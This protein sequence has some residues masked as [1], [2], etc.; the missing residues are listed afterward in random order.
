MTGHN[1]NIYNNSSNT[2]SNTSRNTFHNTFR[3]KIHNRKKGF[4]LIETLLSLTIFLV[5]MAGVYML[6]IHYAKATRTEQSRQRLNQEI[7]FMTNVFAGEIKDV[8]T[9]FTIIH[10]GGYLGA[11]PHWVGI[12]PLNQTVN[13]PDGI[14]IA[15]GDPE[16]VCLLAADY[17]P[18]S[19]T[20]TVQGAEKVQRGLTVP[21][22]DASKQD[23]ENEH[24]D[25]RAGDIAIVVNTDGYYIFHVDAVDVPSNT[26]TIRPEAVYFSGLL[27][28]STG[29]TSTYNYIDNEAMTGDAVTYAEGSPMFRLTNFSIYLFEEFTDTRSGKDVI[30]RRMMRFTDTF[31]EPDVLA[32]GSRATGS[33]ISENIWDLQI[34]YIAYADFTAATRTSTI[35]PAHH[36]FAG[37]AT[38]SSL[39]GL[40]TDIRTRALKQIDVTFVSISDEFGGTGTRYSAEYQIPSIYD[41]P[42][43]NLP[44]RKY[45]FR[46][47]QFIVEPRNFNI[48]Y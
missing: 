22:Y 41:E 36:Y 5:I 48:I 42:A 28:T 37:G 7:R 11:M 34:S 17:V 16:A 46:I 43:Y 25:W 20:L 27:D 21:A 4:T 18:G 35:D 26:L 6:V 9:V 19:G 1:N 10:T 40:L 31:G 23:W 15:T 3:N 29:V 12:T 30:G 45:D 14:I 32:D 2:S 44:N 8:S 13:F 38:S 24:L 47:N 39:I 33:L